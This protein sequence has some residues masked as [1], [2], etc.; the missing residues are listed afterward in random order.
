MQCAQRCILM[1]LAN[2]EPCVPD[3]L[4][5]VAVCF[6]DPKVL[7]NKHLLQEVSSKQGN[8][9]AKPWVEFNVPLS[10]L[11]KLERPKHDFSELDSPGGIQCS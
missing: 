9:E 7:Y 8:A 11:D 3:A 4:P 10:F 5:S 2:P 6:V 1:H